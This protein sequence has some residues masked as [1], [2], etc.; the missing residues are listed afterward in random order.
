MNT[1]IQNTRA[2]VAFRE[3]IMRAET[4]MKQAIADNV[5]T[6]VMGECT[7]THYFTPMSEEYG[8]AVYGRE[9]FLPKGCLIIGKIHRHAHLNFILKGS[10]SVSTEHGKKVMEAPCTFVSEPGLKRAVRALEDTIWTTVHL[11]N[12]PGEDHL[13]EIED[14]VITPDYAQIGAV[15]SLN[16]LEV[17]K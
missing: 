1:E 2:K 3:K 5:L 4:G 10:V 7:L 9:I 14:E 11:T 6:D 13:D 8:C 16:K 15:D 12:T 17:V